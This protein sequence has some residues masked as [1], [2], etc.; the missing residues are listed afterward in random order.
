MVIRQAHSRPPQLF[1][2]ITTQA[3]TQIIKTIL[4]WVFGIVY[5][6]QQKMF[7]C[8]EYIILPVAITHS[9]LEDIIRLS[10][11]PHSF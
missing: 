11:T 7:L 2:V 1:W 5:Q 8:L 9:H 10:V 4:Q 6:I 3:Q